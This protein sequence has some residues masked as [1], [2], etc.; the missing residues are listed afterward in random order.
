ML[1]LTHIDPA[2]NM[3]RYYTIDLQDG[4]LGTVDVIVTNGRIG[5]SGTK[6]RTRSFDTLDDAASYIARLLK[7]KHSRGYQEQ[8]RQNAA[9]PEN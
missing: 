3:S 1:T 8:S 9:G 4:L 2:R 6:P 5:T 7:Q